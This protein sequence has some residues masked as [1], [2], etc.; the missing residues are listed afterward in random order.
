ML[1]LGVRPGGEFGAARVGAEA[2]GAALVLGDRPIEVSL[3]RAWAALPLRRRLQ[4]LA[5]LL[6]VCLAAWHD[7]AVLS[8]VFD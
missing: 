5:G 8:P 4:L 2:V 6:R 3:Q 1:Q 7:S